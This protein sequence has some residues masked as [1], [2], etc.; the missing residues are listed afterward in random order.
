MSARNLDAAEPRVR[1]AV[2]RSLD[3]IADVF[4]E[5]LALSDGRMISLEVEL[6]RALVHALKPA[7]HGYHPAPDRAS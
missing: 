2:T 6:E 7:S 5:I 3:V 1:Q 4:P